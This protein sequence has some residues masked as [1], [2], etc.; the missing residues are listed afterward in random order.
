MP[1]D[2]SGET[3]SLVGR[4]LGPYEVVSPLGAGG[5]GV[6]YRARDTRLGRDVAIKVLPPDVA[7]DPDRLAR[8]QREARATAA[9]SHPNVL[10]V[11]DVG[12]QDGTTFMVTELVRGQTLRE[13]SREQRLPAA[14]VVE[15]GAQIARGLAAAHAAGI[16]H[17]DLKPENVPVTE[18][19]QAK[20]LDF[21]LAKS[22]TAP[23]DQATT[24]QHTTPGVVLG[25]AGYMAPEQ[26]RGQDVDTRADVFALGIVLYELA[27]G[28]PAFR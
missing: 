19:G 23:T 5:M 16:I 26:V 11:F 20:I 6:V 12:T 18:S 17:R 10:A 14:R 9:L 2:R 24:T 15:L 25:T 7:D 27:S 22:T 21:G 28:R 3:E 8:F 1:P 13:L 4:R